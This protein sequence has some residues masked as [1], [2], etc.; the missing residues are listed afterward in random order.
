M[1]H[2][3]AFCMADFQRIHLK[4]HG[5]LRCHR[6]SLSWPKWNDDLVWLFI[7]FKYIQPAG[8]WKW[9]MIWPF[10]KTKICCKQP[11]PNPSVHALTKSLGLPGRRVMFSTVW[12]MSAYSH[13]CMIWN[14]IE[15]L[16]FSPHR[17]E[18]LW[19]TTTYMWIY[20]DGGNLLVY[21]FTW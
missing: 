7:N 17:V 18:L 5:R 16:V 6:N 9:D 15:W 13:R 19:Y 10:G 1:F 14:L 2:P 20:I 11:H 3:R 8:F 4:W 21:Q 12:L